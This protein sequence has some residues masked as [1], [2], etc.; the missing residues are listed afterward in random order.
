M[1]DTITERFVDSVDGVRIATMPAVSAFHEPATERQVVASSEVGECQANMWW[2][3]LAGI[4][5]RR[6]HVHATGDDE[7]SALVGER[8]RR[9]HATD[10]DDGARDDR[11]CRELTSISTHEQQTTTHASAG[12]S[13]HGSVDDDLAAGHAARR[14]SQPG[15]DTF[16]RITPDPE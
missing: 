12:V 15:T 16:A 4:A 13:T 11:P 10:H 9:A 14:A 3:V 1:G 5:V 7:A 6:R 8:R 2:L